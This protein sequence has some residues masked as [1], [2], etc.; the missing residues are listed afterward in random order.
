M[1]KIITIVLLLT[2]GFGVWKYISI[3][4]QQPSMI[5]ETKDTLEKTANYVPDAIDRKNAMENNINDSIAKE[6][7]RLQ[8]SLDEIK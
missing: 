3:K 2:A 4:S 6:S 7:E 8:K 1:K 5:K